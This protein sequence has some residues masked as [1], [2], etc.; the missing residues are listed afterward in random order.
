MV[1]EA[2]TQPDDSTVATDNV[3]VTDGVQVGHISKKNAVEAGA[4]GIRVGSLNRIDDRANTASD[5]R[6]NGKNQIMSPEK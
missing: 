1:Q 4:D 5:G 2:E 3:T 6:P